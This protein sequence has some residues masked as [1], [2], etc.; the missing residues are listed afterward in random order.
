MCTRIPRNRYG[1]VWSPMSVVSFTS[2]DGYAWEYGGVIANWSDT[3]GN[4]WGP[5]GTEYPMMYGP[6]ECDIALLADGTTLLS[7]VRMDGDSGC[8]SGDV[9]PARRNANY[10][11]YRSY[12]ASF[13]TNNGVSWTTPKA[14]EGTVRSSKLMVAF[15]H[16]S[17]QTS[18]LPCDWHR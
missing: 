13:S 10:T 12:A 17:L 16:S 18:H 3:K 2:P 6:T 7:V 1:V 11:V 14:I 8:F 5:P 4:P 15:S 9:P